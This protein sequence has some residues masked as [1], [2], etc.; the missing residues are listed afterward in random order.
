MH[1]EC[2]HYALRVCPY[3]AAPNYG[4]RIDD[5]TLREA[6]LVMI[7]DTMIPERPALFVA[8]LAKTAI[9]TPRG[10][11]VPSQPY[12]RVEYW[13]HGEQ[14]SAAEGGAMADQVMAEGL[15]ARMQQ[16]R[17]FVGGRR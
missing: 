9:M 11:L 14:L 1:D 10:Y 7:D 16:T 4:K 13:L 3:L 2:A 17:V 5:R 8:V 12:L 6:Q 15:P